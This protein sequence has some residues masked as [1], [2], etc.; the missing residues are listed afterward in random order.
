[1]RFLLVTV[2]KIY[3]YVPMNIQWIESKFLF[4]KILDKKDLR[5]IIFVIIIKGNKVKAIL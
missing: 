3:F 5:N 1:M 2:I 4:Y